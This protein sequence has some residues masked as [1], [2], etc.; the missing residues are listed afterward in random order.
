MFDYFRVTLVD[1][2][3]RRLAQL[4]DEDAD[5]DGLNSSAAVVDEP[6]TISGGG[7]GNGGGA[8]GGVSRRRGAGIVT[9][10]APSASL[11]RFE[12]LY[13]MLTAHS[14]ESRTLSG[15]H[16]HL[17]LL[18]FND[19]SLTATAEVYDWVLFLIDCVLSGII[20][21]LSVIVMLS[22]S[23]F[24][25]DPQFQFGEQLSA[26]TSRTMDFSV[27]KFEPIRKEQNTFFKRYI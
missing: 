20:F 2:A 16:W 9:P 27:L 19:T 11:R 13:A 5:V 1:S 26:F 25:F 22:F 14:G 21:Q 18:R 23:F 24:F 17:P 12:R 4:L 10:R 8:G 6:H 15:V 7:G 3:D